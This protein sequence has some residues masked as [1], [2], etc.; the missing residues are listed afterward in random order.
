[1]KTQLLCILLILSA[2]FFQSCTNT[3]QSDSFNTVTLNEIA[4]QLGANQLYELP[5]K[6][7]FIDELL[8]LIVSRKDSVPVEFPG[9]YDSLALQIPADTLEQLVLVDKLEKQGF[10]IQKWTR[11]NF[12]NGPRIVVVEMEKEDCHCTVSKKYY[13]NTISSEHWEMTETIACT[14]G[15]ESEIAQFKA[16][17]K[18]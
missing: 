6:A 18:K 8:N 13:A 9:L 5:E 16:I 10:S 1:M 4:P 2:I 7:D 11:G 3:Q 17:R 15:S 14:R 12:A